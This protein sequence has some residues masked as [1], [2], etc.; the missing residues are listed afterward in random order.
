MGGASFRV[1]WLMCEMGMPPDEI[2]RYRI[3]ERAMQEAGAEVPLARGAQSRRWRSTG[4]RSSK[5]RRSC[6]ISARAAP[7]TA[8]DVRRG[9]RSGCGISS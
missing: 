4:G 1:L 5:A 6:S 8:S 7:S 9:M 2:I 3:G